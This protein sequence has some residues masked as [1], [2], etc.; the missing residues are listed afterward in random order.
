VSD[1][2]SVGVAVEVA[3]LAPSEAAVMYEMAPGGARITAEVTQPAIGPQ[4]HRIRMDGLSL[5]GAD[6]VLTGLQQHFEAL[7]VDRYG[8]AGAGR[9]EQNQ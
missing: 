9:G 3:G 6:E 4:R 8:P 1:P 2:A 5:A 7:G